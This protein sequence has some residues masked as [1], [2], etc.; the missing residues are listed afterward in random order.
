LNLYQRALATPEAQAAFSDAALIEAMLRFELALAQAQGRL[1]LIPAQAAAAIARHGAGLT[2][3]AEVL[4]REAANAGSLAIPFVKAL[5]AHVGE[6]AR[7]AAR[8]VHFGATSQDV[9]DSAAA[10]CTRRAVH[11]MDAALACASRAAATLASRH[12]ETPI[13]ARTLMQPAGVTSFGLK[14]AHWAQS[15]ARGR[16]RVLDTARTAL[17]VSLGGPIGNLAAYGE[18]GERLRAELAASLELHDPGASW[19]THRER[20]LA[21]AADAAL[22]AGSMLKIARDI[23]LMTQ[24]EVGEACEPEKPGRGASTAMPH[25]RNPVLAMRVIAAAHGIPGALANVMAAMSQEHERGLG[26]WQAELAQW[27][28]VFIGGLSAAG[29][30]A[31]L[32]EGLRLDSARCRRNIDAL[33]GVVFAAELAEL[34][35]P[36]L[37]RPQAHERVGQL[38]RLAQEEGVHLRDL[39]AALLRDDLRLAACTPEHLDRIFDVDRAAQASARLVAPM[40][41]ALS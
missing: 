39:A 9:L 13:L 24:P 8:F 3:D 21:L 7:E 32:L 31:E 2:V 40:L 6:H 25:K 18:L 4:A 15:L 1:G 33:H 16:N 19:H 10:V 12:S 34:L 28:D 26:T 23:A 5:T 38:A 14:A 11:A 29:A 30:L 20:W 35:A 36:A 22:A 17:A 41:G 27:P 37:G